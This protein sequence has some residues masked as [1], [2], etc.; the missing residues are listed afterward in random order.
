MVDPYTAYMLK[1]AGDISSSIPQIEWDNIRVF[2]ANYGRGD[3]YINKIAKSEREKM[4]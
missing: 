3:I 2:V 4:T 1:V